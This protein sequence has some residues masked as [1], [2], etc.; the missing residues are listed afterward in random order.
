MKLH[1]EGP[2]PTVTQTVS[3]HRLHLCEDVASGMAELTITTEGGQ[4]ALTIELGGA[5]GVTLRFDQADLKLANKGTMAFECERFRVQAKD[6]D[7]E[8]SGTLR[9]RAAGDLEQVAGKT[10]R[11]VGHEVGIVA[12]RGDVRV[13]ANDDVRLDGERIWLNR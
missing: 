4:I 13:R 6:V 9:T 5:Q 3:G 2:M 11:V 10:A 1:T 8:S 12:R 7:V